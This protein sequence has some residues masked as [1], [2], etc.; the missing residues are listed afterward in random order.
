[1][2]GE[3]SKV[4]I[5]GA[6][7]G[8]FMCCI[9]A[10]LLLGVGF[11]FYPT[12]P[13]SADAT[14]NPA[15]TGTN[16]PEE[17]TTPTPTSN[18]TATHVPDCAKHSKQVLI[19]VSIVNDNFVLKSSEECHMFSIGGGSRGQPILGEKVN[20]EITIFNQTY[21]HYYRWVI[22]IEGQHHVAA[23]GIYVERVM[24]FQFV[25]NGF[26]WADTYETGQYWFLKKYVRSPTPTATPTP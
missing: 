6:I 5:A 10:I 3:K 4:F 13:Y 23:K 21:D 7:F 15:I 8:M 17:I 11:V 18:I 24:S 22:P 20:E 14:A 9:G 1:M 12:T 2:L 26:G 19:Q 25:G 16:I